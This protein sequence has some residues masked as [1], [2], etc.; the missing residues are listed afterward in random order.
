MISPVT[1]PLK[2]WNG[3]GTWNL[4]LIL[5]CKHCAYLRIVASSAGYRICIQ[6]PP[7]A[8]MAKRN[9]FVAH[10]LTSSNPFA[11][12]H[13]IV[14]KWNKSKVH[15]LS[16]C[17]QNHT[18]LWYASMA[19][20]F[21]ITYRC[22]YVILLGFPLP[23]WSGRFLG[24]IGWDPSVCKSNRLHIDSLRFSF[25]ELGNTLWIPVKW[26]VIFLQSWTSTVYF[27]DSFGLFVTNCRF[28][29]S[30]LCLHPKISVFLKTIFHLR[31]KTYESTQKP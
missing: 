25:I 1:H 23:Q 13:N 18:C 7:L 16:N 3:S 29:P 21:V 22:A 31:I 2:K 6:P 9:P 17:K 4:A 19:V 10:L 8:H 28:S 27:S 11:A 20:E 15:K 24:I 12:H 30:L 5:V 14:K 26:S